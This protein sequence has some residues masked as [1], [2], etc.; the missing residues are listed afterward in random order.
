MKIFILHRCF[1]DSDKSKDCGRCFAGG[2]PAM[3]R[4]ERRCDVSGDGALDF[5]IRRSVEFGRFSVKKHTIVVFA[6]G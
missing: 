1:L 5:S 4:S 2:R 6:I 3:F